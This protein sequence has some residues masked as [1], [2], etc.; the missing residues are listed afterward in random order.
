MLVS[1]QCTVGFVSCMLSGRT[2]IRK[3]VDRC[4][5]RGTLHRFVTGGQLHVHQ[6]ERRA[7]NGLPFHQPHRKQMRN[8]HRSRLV[9]FTIALCSY[10]FAATSGAAAQAR[11]T[12]TSPSVNSP[13]IAT[14]GRGEV[15]VA[16]DLARLQITVETRSSSANAAAADNA[17]RLTRTIAAVRAAG[18][19]SAQISTSGYSV[20][21]DYDARNRPNGFVVRNGLRIE[22]RRIADVGKI[23]DAALSPGATQ[24]NG[25]QF[26]RSDVHESRRSALTL[27]VGEARRDAE[28][29]AQAAGGT[30]GRMIYLTSG[31]ATVPQPFDFQSGVVVTSL[32]SGTRIMPGDLTVTAVANA[33]WQFLPRQGP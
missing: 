21:T 13:Q 6:T 26:L 30:L 23:I 19:D 12:T 14:N 9:R 7:S 33:V 16:P 4:R 2:R 15:R 8:T 10:I 31:F 5:Q 29:L 27:A 22:V 11:E 32:E 17:L 3:A 24:V 20:S 1:Y 18:I 28:A 25:V